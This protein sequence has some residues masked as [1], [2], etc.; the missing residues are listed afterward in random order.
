MA[1]TDLKLV[2]FTEHFLD[3]KSG[4][5]FICA[6]LN[7][8]EACKVYA[9]ELS[10]GILEA[11]SILKRVKLSCSFSNSSS[12]LQALKKLDGLES[13]GNKF[14]LYKNDKIRK[15]DRHF[16]RALSFFE[17]FRLKKMAKR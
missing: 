3:S 17:N 13:T 8:K 1:E 15:S 14:R 7:K 12:L 5:Y 6:Y 11:E 4:T 9:A 10:D 2:L 16:Y